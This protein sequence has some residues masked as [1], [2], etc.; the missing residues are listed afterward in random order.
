MADIITSLNDFERL[1]AGMQ[2]ASEKAR[3]SARVMWMLGEFIFSRDTAA[4]QSLRR[5]SA[6]TWA[7]QERFGRDPALQ[8]TGPGADTIDL[9][10]VIYP[11]YRGGLGQV[12]A[13]RK[14]AGKGRPQILVDGRGV[15]YGRWS[16]LG[17]EETGS[18]FMSNGTPRKIEFRISLQRYG[19]DSFENS[20]SDTFGGLNP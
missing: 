17:V 10:G 13:M 14:L 11:H 5:S 8:F 12:D 7:S 1:R 19:E 20:G 6:F 18:V 16:I 3:K 9:D 2:A 15:V 4:P